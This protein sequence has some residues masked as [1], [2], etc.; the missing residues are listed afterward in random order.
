MF[1]ESCLSSTF[2]KEWKEVSKQGTISKEEFLEWYRNPTNY[3]PELPSTNR[4]HQY[5]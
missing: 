1:N 4:C 3:H 5:E 2:F